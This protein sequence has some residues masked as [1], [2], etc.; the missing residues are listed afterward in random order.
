MSYKLWDWICFFFAILA[1]VVQFF[2]VSHIPE[3]LRPLPLIV[4]IV[5]SVYFLAIRNT[6]D[7]SEPLPSNELPVSPPSEPGH[8]LNDAE[9]AYKYL[10]ERYG[11]GY[12]QLA[13]AC[14]VHS[15]G[16]AEVR[17]RVEVKAYSEIRQLDTFL[18]IPESPPPGEK[19]TIDPL[20]VRSLSPDYNV[21]RRTFG[22]Q[23]R[24]SALIMI[25]PQLGAGEQFTYEL[26]EQLPAS[27]YAIDLAEE[28]LAER[29]TSYDYFGWS[30]NR[31]T[32]KLSLKVYFPEEVK[33]EVYGF[34]VRYASAAPGIPSESFHLEERKRFARPNLIGPQGGRY[35][36]TLEVDHPMIGLIYIL[37][38]QPLKTPPKKM[39]RQAE[40]TA[41]PT[42]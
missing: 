22:Q 5:C 38:W 13:V 1:L 3:S 28:K 2:V 30:I 31:P 4:L 10:A 24:L 8:P 6:I 40:E 25:S 34:E 16:S 29:K 15:D 23:G 35:V 33:P 7:R 9:E 20:Q 17:R 32:R 11:I 36:L 39:P 27:L 19:W 26:T 41:E 37:R 14:T 42:E 18:L 12:D 21:S